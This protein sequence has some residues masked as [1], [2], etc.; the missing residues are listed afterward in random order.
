MVGKGYQKF[1]PDSPFWFTAQV[2]P[3]KRFSSSAKV[4]LV[5]LSQK[6]TST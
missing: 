2:L 4:V 1:E 6:V 5:N 3:Y